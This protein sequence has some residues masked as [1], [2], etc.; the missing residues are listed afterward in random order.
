M[1]KRIL[2]ICLILNYNIAQAAVINQNSGASSDTSEDFE[3]LTFKLAKKYKLIKGLKDFEKEDDAIFI[4]PHIFY[5]Q[6]YGSDAT[7]DFQ[8]GAG[9]NLGYQNKRWN[10]YA[11]LGILRAAFQYNEN[12]TITDEERNSS[13]YGVGTAWQLTNNLAF[14]LESKFY[15]IEFTDK[16][17]NEFSSD[18]IAISVGLAL[19]F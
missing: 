9:F 5:D 3:V 11:S 13:F 15:E 19:D 12:G 2:V 17:G 14:L 16:S 4:M 7:L 1:L 6:F 8:Y 18:N 10:Y